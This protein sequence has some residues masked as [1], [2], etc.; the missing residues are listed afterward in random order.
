MV[1]IVLWKLNQRRKQLSY[2]ILF[3][4]ALTGARS[5]VR[6]RL[7]V[8][9][10]GKSVKDAGLVIVQV[11]NSGHLPIPPGDVQSRLHINVGPGAKVLYA[12]VA[13]TSPGDLDERCRTAAGE[14]KSLVESFSGNEVVLA[15]VLLNEGDSFIVQMLVENLQG[16]V[17][18]SG[19]ING[20]RRITPWRKRSG[21]STVFTNV[22]ALVMCAAVLFFEPRQIMNY[23]LAE[24]LPA[25]LFFLFG[26]TLLSAGIYAKTKQTTATTLG[27]VT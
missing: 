24:A 5:S 22:G 27:S 1:S 9:F 21:V 18:V 12:D 20:I 11:M 16:G 17:K 23:G 26:Y 3:Q 14:R 15:P 25:V 2:K 7:D 6:Q 4:D 13:S 8:T 19:H 10:D